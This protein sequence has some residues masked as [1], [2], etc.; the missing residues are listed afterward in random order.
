MLVANKSAEDI[1]PLYPWI[2]YR[3]AVLAFSISNWLYNRAQLHNDDTKVRSFGE[4]IAVERK[5]PVSLYYMLV[6]PIKHKLN[7]AYKL[8]NIVLYAKATKT[9]LV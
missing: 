3:I 4:N 5:K 7:F 8:A 1:V 6:I 9:S 2:L